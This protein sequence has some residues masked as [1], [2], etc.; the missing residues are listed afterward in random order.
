M[1][2]STSAP[3]W[4]AARVNRADK[5]HGTRLVLLDAAAVVF[6]RSG[7]ARTTVAD[8][9]EQ[10]QVS[11]PSFYA[12]FAAKS[13]IF[14]E[15]AARVRDEFLA[16]HEIPGVDESDPY[17][18]GR[19]SSAALLAAY[20]ANHEL[21]AV[22]EH[23][24]LTE[25]AIAAVWREIEARPARRMV[26]YVRRLTEQGTAHPAASP[27]IVAQALIG[28]FA[29]FGRALPAEAAQFDELVESVTAMY[30]RLIG[31]DPASPIGP[32]GPGAAG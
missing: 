3:A 18:L 9:T 20:A 14:G 5:G 24:A 1:S 2:T 25:P 26:R 28:I 19:A 22:I 30:L 6:A 16:A 23:Q 7:Y 21:L 32:G 29:R 27:E 12:Y 10:A 8:I 17:A 4:A 15:V 31:V 11:R 13:E